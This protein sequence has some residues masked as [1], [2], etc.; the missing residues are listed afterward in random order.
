MEHRGNT[1]GLNC[2]LAS[3]NKDSKYIDISP[4]DC[5]L[6]VANS[7]FCLMVYLE[8][9]DAKNGLVEQLDFIF[10]PIFHEDH[11]YHITQQFNNVHKVLKKLI[12]PILLRTFS[13]HY[14]IQACHAT[15]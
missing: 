8:C 6:P 3:M 12:G 13:Q 2:L 14:G 5:N 15:I 10:D 4:V 7:Y 9:T 11:N 1:T